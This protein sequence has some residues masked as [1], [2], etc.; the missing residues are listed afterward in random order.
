MPAACVCLRPR[1]SG[2]Q[3]ANVDDD[4]HKV[5]KAESNKVTTSGPLQPKVRAVSPADVRRTASGRI[6]KPRSSDALQSTR[7]DAGCMRVVGGSQ[8]SQPS[9]HAAEHSLLQHEAAEHR[10]DV[11]Q[12][13][14]KSTSKRILQ[15]CNR[16]PLTAKQPK[17]PL[18]RLWPFKRN[19][20]S[21]SE[22][23]MPAVAPTPSKSILE[24]SVRRVERHTQGAKISNAASR[25]AAVQAFSDAYLLAL[26]NG[27]EQWAVAADIAAL[28]ASDVIL[29]THDKQT[30]YGRT[31][32]LRRL[33]SGMDRPS[34][35][36]P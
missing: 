1:R 28:F 24:A 27:D 11:Q 2:P 7:N 5:Y 15:P 4:D 35:V 31:A 25:P 6:V 23:S 16:M 10:H 14:S 18:R 33:N 13:D 32:V 3:H 34:Y 20:S 22:P 26:A 17:S 21:N 19:P 36:M 12:Q 30:F 9:R 29:K 8:L